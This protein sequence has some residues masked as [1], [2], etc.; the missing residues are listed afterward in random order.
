VTTPEQWRGFAEVAADAAQLS[1]LLMETLRQA[2]LPILRM[3]PSSAA[4]GE[5]GKIVQYHLS[6]IEQ[7]LAHHLIPLVHGDVAFDREIGGTVISTE[8]VFFYLARQLR[9]STII[10][11]GEVNGVY[12]ETFTV[13]PEITP[14][15]M[16]VVRPALG[17]SRGTDV[18]GGM[19]TKVEDM[20]AL[21]QAV[22]G[23]SIFIANGQQR[24]VLRRLILEHESVGTHLYSP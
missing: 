20:L 5:G 22:E 13:F 24:G 14:A 18:T 12:D 11:L 1:T 2:G 10:L 4:T 17:G 9:P 19:L 6:P 23:L 3:P 8:K 16:D 21:A 15:N 7:A